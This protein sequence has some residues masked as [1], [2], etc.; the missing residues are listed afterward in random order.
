MEQ[1]G[2]KRA[3]MTANPGRPEAAQLLAIRCRR[4]PPVCN[5]HAA[6]T[7]VHGW[8][9]GAS[10]AFCQIAGYINML[11][12]HTSTEREHVQ[13]GPGIRDCFLT[14]ARGELDP[15]SPEKAATLMGLRHATSGA[16]GS[17]PTP[18]G[19]EVHA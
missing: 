4:L 10:S 9:S 17:G 6:S 1:S 8:N 5:V 19:G 15:L 14:P 7:S 11:W 12:G 13:N 16:S 18:G 3:Q 2:R